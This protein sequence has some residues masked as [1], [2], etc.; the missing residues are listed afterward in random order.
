MKFECKIYEKIIF[1]LACEE[2]VVPMNLEKCVEN[3]LIHHDFC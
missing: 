2:V 1:A 3:M